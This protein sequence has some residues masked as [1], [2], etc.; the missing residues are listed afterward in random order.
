MIITA[1]ERLTSCCLEYIPRL[2]VQ[3]AAATYSSNWIIG[4]L[5]VMIA[6]HGRVTLCSTLLSKQATILRALCLRES[7]ETDVLR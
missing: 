2:D 3:D 5:L 1:R 7:F 4:E 6:S